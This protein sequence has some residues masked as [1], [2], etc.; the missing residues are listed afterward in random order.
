L[1]E[2]CIDR[3]GKEVLQGVINRRL[4]EQACK[5][6]NIT[7][8]EADLDKEIA[9][10][11]STMV[12]ARPDGSPDVDAWMK[13]VTEQQGISAEVYR[14]D[15]VWPSVALAKLVGNKIE[16]TQDDLQ[17]GYEAN[18]GPRVRCRA[19]VLDNLRRAQEAWEKARQTPTEEN[20]AQLA[21]QYSMDPA[22]RALRGEFPPIQRHGGMPILEKEAFEL[23]PGELSSVLSVDSRYVILFCLGQTKPVE[24]DPNEVRELIRQDVHEKKQHIAMADYFDKLQESATIDNYLEGSSHSP[25]NVARAPQAKPTGPVLR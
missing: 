10:V 14:R 4:L 17:K 3:H 23:K 15:S 21:E 11:A 13:L 25:K 18:Y 22:S 6:A 5:K 9:R 2:L 24:V 7:V 12:P 20:F 16:V 8:T 1:A 19:I